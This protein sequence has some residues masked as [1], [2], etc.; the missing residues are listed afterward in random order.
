MFRVRQPTRKKTNVTLKLKQGK[1]VLKRN[2]QRK[3]KN[4]RSIE[5]ERDLQRKIVEVIAMKRVSL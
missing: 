4:L 2:K 3:V 1:Y 5:D